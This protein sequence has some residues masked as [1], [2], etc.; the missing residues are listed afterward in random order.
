MLWQPKIPDH[1][2]ADDP[3]SIAAQIGVRR[4]QLGDRLLILGHHYQQDDVVRHADL[5][6]DRL[7]RGL[8]DGL[9]IPG[10]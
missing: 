5:T 1:Y 2:L 4:E 10:A 7:W 3:E 6:G 9:A 8:H